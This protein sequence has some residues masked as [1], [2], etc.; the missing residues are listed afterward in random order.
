MGEQQFLK[1]TKTPAAIFLFLWCTVQGQTSLSLDQAIHIAIENNDKIH[2]YQE[3][4]Q[5]KKYEEKS[6]NGNFFPTVTLSGSYN[7]LD[8]P[9]TM[10]LDP[11]RQ[12]MLSLQASNQVS[13]ASI[14]SQIKGGSAITENT[15]QY[16]SYYSAAYSALDSKL[17]HFIDT[18]KVQNY[19][20][21][22]VTIVQPLFVGGKII[23]GSRAGKADRKAAEAE[24]QKTQNE[25]IQE[26]I[27]Y[28]LAVVVTRDVV[29]VRKEVLDGMLQHQKNAERYLAEGLI[30]RYHLL[31]AQVAV[32]EARRNLIDAQSQNEIAIL[33]LRKNLNY[34]DSLDFTVLDSLVYI[35]IKDSVNV[36]LTSSENEQPIY[37]LIDQKSM[38]ARQKV[39][40]QTSALMPQIAA[41]GRYEIFQKYLSALEPN[42]IVGVTASMDLFSG[43]RNVNN[44]QAAKHLVKEVDEMKSGVHHDISL[45]IN[46]TYK[47]MRAAE[48]RYLQLENDIKLSDE[49]YR[50][51]QKRFESGYGTSLEVIDAQLVREKDRIDRLLSLLDYY[52]SLNGLNT[53]SGKAEQTV[54]FLKIKE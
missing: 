32:S 49:N 52:R 54:T 31:R 51:A 46:K 28:W 2:Q 44:L 38:L 14:A 50:Q 25:I 8:K 16:A 26:T 37:E 20:E 21:A 41:F 39:A 17:P 1:V 5:Q 19:P 36:F 4:V 9:L 48:E 7:H 10:D 40:A 3:Q 30:S 29:S 23:A 11:I 15:A 43:L 53:A 33:A 34:S 22:A 18:L 27:N 24:L 12:A 45:L 47:E 35:P 6:A 42:W 13:L